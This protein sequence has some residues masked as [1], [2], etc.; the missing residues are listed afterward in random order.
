MTRNKN[1]LQTFFLLTVLISVPAWSVT[2]LGVYGIEPALLHL[3]AASTM[4]LVLLDWVLTWGTDMYRV[5]RM[6]DRRRALTMLALLLV[7]LDVL[8]FMT[9]GPT[10]G[11]TLAA[12]SVL[13]GTFVVAIIL[14]LAIAVGTAFK[15][16]RWLEL[17]RFG[18]RLG[19][20]D[21]TRSTIAAL[22]R[23]RASSAGNAKSM[24]RRRLAIIAGFGAALL[25]WLSTWAASPGSAFTLA[26][27]VT[28]IVLLGFMEM[29]Q[30]KLS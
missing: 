15:L 17:S 29:L 6:L 30:R 24:V 8:E 23:F 13:S 25:V 19:G 2:V 7:G 20:L 21:S 10:N 16:D 1:I 26:P 18:E 4:G 22:A 27:V 12:T 5:R 28:V 9:S 3:L 11:I 14:V